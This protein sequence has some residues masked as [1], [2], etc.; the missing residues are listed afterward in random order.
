M[1][2]K[3]YLNTDEMAELAALEAEK[4]A[5]ADRYNAKWK[6]LKSRGDARMR[7]DKQRQSESRDVD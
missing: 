2:W 4:Q 3:D 7:R 1:S 6:V 5:A